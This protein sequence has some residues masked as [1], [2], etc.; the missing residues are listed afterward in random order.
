MG[1]IEESTIAKR[2]YDLIQYNFG[3]MDFFISLDEFRDLLLKESYAHLTNGRIP[4]IPNMFVNPQT[5]NKFLTISKYKDLVGGV[6][7]WALSKGYF[8]STR[9]FVGFRFRIIKPKVIPTDIKIR[10]AVEVELTDVEAL[11]VKAKEMNIPEPQK[12]DITPIRI[13]NSNN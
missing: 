13:P 6:R 4:T 9:L 10:T 5:S 12:V 1:I 11:K 3:A 2:Y 8:K 7:F